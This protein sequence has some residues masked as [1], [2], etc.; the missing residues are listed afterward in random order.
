MRVLHKKF[1]VP[2][3]DGTPF[4]AAETDNYA[5]VA[6]IPERRP[7]AEEISGVIEQVTFHPDEMAS[8]SSGLK[9]G[10][11]EAASIAIH[12]IFSRARISC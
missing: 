4:V 12:R 10:H 7:A 2:V 1:G 6:A 11:R 8:V 3:S 9:Q 5:T